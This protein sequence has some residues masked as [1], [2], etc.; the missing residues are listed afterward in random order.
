MRSP[1]VAIGKNIHIYGLLNQALKMLLHA[2]QIQFVPMLWLFRAHEIS[3]YTE[4]QCNRI[5]CIILTLYF[6]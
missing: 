3:V 4:R 1:G 2:H 6:G 5:R